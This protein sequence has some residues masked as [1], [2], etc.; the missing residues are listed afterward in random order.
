MADSWSL[1]ALMRGLLERAERLSEEYW[2][3]RIDWEDGIAL[4]TLAF[5]LAAEKQ[6]GLYVDAGAGVGYSTLWILYGLAASGCSGC[7]LVAVEHDPGRAGALRMLLG[8]AVS[9]LR[10]AGAP[11]PS[12][13]AV[14]GDALEY[15]EKLEPGQPLMVMVDIDKHGYPEALRLLEER[16]PRGGVAAFHNALGPMPLPPG[17]RGMV[18]EGPWRSLVLPTRQ[19]LLVLE[20]T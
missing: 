17:F 10:D 12:V 7:S 2:V 6:G 11:A 8:E 4:A 16:L 1:L 15:L 13:E 19:G 14:E 20:K 9:R 18:E 3:P 5:R